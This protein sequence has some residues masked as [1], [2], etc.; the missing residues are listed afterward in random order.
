MILDG[1]KISEER[2][3]LLREEIARSGLQPK[4]ATVIVGDDPASRLYVRMKQQACERVGIA[5]VSVE[6]PVDCAVGSL[7]ARINDLN[8]DTSIDGILV[9]LPLPAQIRPE[10]VTSAIAPEKDV[11]GFNPL[12]LGKLL[13]GNP[14][15]VPCTPMGIMT[16]LHTY[17][18]R[19]EGAEA[20]VIG[21]SIEVGR[22]CA[23][24]LLNA[25]ATVTICH[26]RTSNL[27][28]HIKRADIVI[29]A[30][31]KARF[32]NAD[33]IRKGATIIDVG[34]NYEDGKLCGDVDFEGVQQK[35]GAITPVPGGVGPMTIVSLMENTFRAARMRR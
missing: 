17:G 29:S 7:L 8:R 33:M 19:T 10:M 15:F 27:K 20:V 9:Q 16:L 24:M 6:L 30:A 34:I 28:S 14:L 35:A 23:V 31:G 2:L 32:I 26:S 5:S 21:R 22:P 1:K 18:I 12:N 25:H 13:S 11:D 4:L 3:S